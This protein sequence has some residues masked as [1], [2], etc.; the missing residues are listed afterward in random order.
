MKKISKKINKLLVCIIAM[1]SIN[2]VY[3]LVEKESNKSEKIGFVI[4]LIISILILASLC[5][6]FHL[7]ITR[8]KYLEDKERKIILNFNKSINIIRWIFM[9]VVY[10]AFVI[11]L[12]LIMITIMYCLEG[13]GKSVTEI[14]IYSP[15]SAATKH[16]IETI[17]LSGLI[18][19]LSKVEHVIITYKINKLKNYNDEEKEIL[20]QYYK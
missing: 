13:L 16:F 19:A 5:T 15:M 17:L 7:R 9:I 14:V 6:Y 11:N 18:L 10:L 3:A 4:Y 8:T 20:L 12:F 1:L 2:N